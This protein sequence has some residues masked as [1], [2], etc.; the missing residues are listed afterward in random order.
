[1]EFYTRLKVVTSRWPGHAAQPSHGLA[2]P[3]TGG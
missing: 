2:F 1:V 3:R